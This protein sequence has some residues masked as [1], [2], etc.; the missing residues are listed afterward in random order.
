MR[1]GNIM[2]NEKEGLNENK[3]KKTNID[4]R[5]L[6]SLIISLITIAMSI[7]IVVTMIKVG[8]LPFKY[9]IVLTLG[10]LLLNGTLGFILLKN[11]KGKK[12]RNIINVIQVMLT[13]GQILVMIYVLKT[14]SFINKM[15][16]GTDTKKQNYSVIVLK[17]SEYEN[18]EDLEG[19]IIEYYSSEL[20][21]SE[22]ALEELKR[23][24]DV[25]AVSN[26]DVILVGKTLLSGEVDAILIED[27]QKLLLEEEIEGFSDTTKVIYT[28]SIDISVETIAKSAE[29]TSETFAVYISG[30]DTYGTIS[31]VSRSD[32]NIVAVINPKTYQVLLVNIPRD[33]YVKLHGT[34]GKRDK[35]THAGM[36][37][38]EMSVKTIEDLLDMDINYYF[39]VNFTSLEDI[40]DAIG[41]IEVY[42]EYSFTSVIG[43]YKF[44]A[45][46]N[47][48]NGK[49]A[50]AFARER[51][52]FTD[53]D[54]MRGKNQQAVIN[55]IIKQASKPSII[56]KF[57]TLLKS[58]S[59]K[60]QTNMD[61]SKMMELVKL[62]ISKTP[63][64][65]VS[66]ISLTGGDGRAS[67]YSS[68][69]QL[70][71]VMLPSQNS[72]NDAIAKID[73][74]IAGEILEASYESVTGN[75]YVPT[76][77]EAYATPIEKEE[78]EETP[79]EELPT[80]EV[81]DGNENPDGDTT[82]DTDDGSE[83]ETGNGTTN[84]GS[85]TN[86]G[87]GD[88]TDDTPTIV[89]PYGQSAN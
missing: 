71:Y 43:R 12:A 18:I 59:N 40:V 13:I 49:Q 3:T 81:V 45:G 31:S 23:K 77:A 20:D 29:V 75:V 70:L 10:L 2:T 11:R 54:R 55:G 8:I 73:A 64:W 21:N 57:D 85:D 76:A 42:S 82:I 67:T 79:E 1:K 58:L 53:G 83:G 39:K 7:A 17:D 47:S 22:L 38:V 87:T 80:D 89:D 6:V 69:S 60:F 86:E 48:M 72:I 65:N 50:L 30:I 88:T 35:L 4:K 41:G 52:A 15:N 37:G 28:F 51:K 19:K 33:Y 68:G 46:Y 27:S 36:Y 9:M 25:S 61:T 16:E 74:V 56:T 24:V 44:K 34:S 84:E 63:T 62:Q 78:P 26:E 32:V 5:K 14:Y 66:T